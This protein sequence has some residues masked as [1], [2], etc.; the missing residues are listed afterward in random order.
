M[1]SRYTSA[2]GTSGIGLLGTDD[3]SRSTAELLSHVYALREQGLGA[4]AYCGGYHIP[5]TTLT[6][7][8]R[9]DIV[10]SDALIGVGEVAISDHRSSQPTLDDVLRL[11]SEAHVSGLMTGKAGIVH[12][13]LG[14]GPRGLELVR[15]ALDT[16]EPVSYTHLDVYK[17]QV[18]DSDP[19]SEWDE[20][21]NKGRALFRAVAEAARGL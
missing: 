20:T 12:L 2:G 1:L 17:R 3:V 6:G 9:G 18:Y 16:S 5:P 15:Q 8:V 11:A 7:S 13:H 10:F 19:Q 21:M 14:D 4:W